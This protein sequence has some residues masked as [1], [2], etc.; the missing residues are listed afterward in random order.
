PST[1]RPGHPAA[2]AR[3]TAGGRRPPGPPRRRGA[4]AAGS[5]NPS[6]LATPSRKETALTQPLPVLTD[7]ELSHCPP[8]EEGGLGALRTA[9]GC[10]PLQAMHVH[11]QIEGLLAHVTLSQTFVNTLDEP[12]EAGYVFP[13]P[14]RLAVTGFTLEVAGREVQGVLRERAAARQ[15]YR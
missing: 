9:K 3:P 4:L 6:A 5:R 13:L 7:D 1:P 12:L 10:L 11:G 2:G 15:D 8:D 14:D